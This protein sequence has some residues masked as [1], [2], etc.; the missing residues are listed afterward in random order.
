MKNGG[1]TLNFKSKS[2]VLLLF[3][4]LILCMGVV[5]ANND[6]DSNATLTQQSSSNFDSTDNMLSSQSNDN[7]LSATMGTFKD[8]QNL[9]DTTSGN[10]LALEGDYVYDAG[11]D[12]SLVNGIVINKTFTISSA[13]G[14]KIVINGGNSARL[15]NVTGAVTFNNISFINGNAVDGGAIYSNSTNAITFN[16]CDFIKNTASND[17]GAIYKNRPANPSGNSYVLN[18]CNFYNNTAANYGGAV[19]IAS[20]YGTTTRCRYIDNSANKGGVFYANKSR[21]TASGS[22]FYRNSANTAAVVLISDLG[23][24]NYVTNFANSII[25]QNPSS[26]T[27][28]SRKLFFIED[29]VSAG[30]FTLNNNWWGTT[31]S[32]NIFNIRDTIGAVPEHATLDLWLYLTNDFYFAARNSTNEL[33]FSLSHQAGPSTNTTYNSVNVP[34]F[35]DLIEATSASVGVAGGASKFNATAAYVNYTA[36]ANLAVNSTVTLTLT[37]GGADSQFS[38]HIASDGSYTA[39]Q[40]LI[41]SADSSLYLNRDYGYDSDFD[42]GLMITGVIINKPFIFNGNNHTIDGK[43]L[44]AVISV[45][46]D[47]VILRN[48][49]IDN[50]YRGTSIEGAGIYWKANNAVIDHITTNYCYNLRSQTWQGACIIFRDVGNASNV[51][52][53]NSV[54]NGDD[55]IPNDSF[56]SGIY[57]YPTYGGN[58][59]LINVTTDHLRASTLWVYNADNLY[60]EGCSFHSTTTTSESPNVVASVISNCK[61]VTYVNNYLNFHGTVSFTDN[62]RV[63]NSEYINFTNNTFGSNFRSRGNFAIFR[64]SVLLYF[65]NNTMYRPP[66]YWSN[67]V[68]ALGGLNTGTVIFKDNFISTYNGNGYVV[69]FDSFVDVDVYNNTF[70]YNAKGNDRNV[71][72]ISNDVRVDIY[73][74][75]FSDNHMQLI[76]A[77]NSQELYIYNNTVKRNSTSHGLTADQ[78]FSFLNMGYVLFE[79]NT[80]NPH[81]STISTA[82]EGTMLSAINSTITINNNKFDGYSNSANNAFVQGIFY[83]DNESSTNITNNNFSNCRVYA[84]TGMGLICNLGNDTLICN[85][86]FY[87]TVGNGPING[88]VIYNTG[89]NVTI[90]NNTFNTTNTKGIGG[91]I[92]N[93]GDDVFI[94]YNNFTTN[95]ASNT[96]VIYS[97]GHNVII[98]YCNVTNSYSTS[99]VGAF[100]IEGLANISN[101]Y[102]EKIHAVTDY[103]V[104]YCD[105]AEG[106]IIHNITYLN[107]YATANGMLA[108]G[109]NITIYDQNFTNNYVTNG[110]AGSILIKGNDNNLTNIY[111]YKTRASF[112]GAISNNGDY[113]NITNL[114]IINSTATFSH[115]GAIY[116]IGNNL[117]INILN[118]SNTSSLQDG[119]AIYTTV[120]AGNSFNHISI[121]NTK[122]EHD[123]GAIYCG[124][125]DAKIYDINITNSQSER[126]GGSIY[127][128]G[129]NGNISIMNIIN[130]TAGDSGGAIYWT[131]SEGKLD[132]VTINHTNAS[133]G[134]AIYWT[135]ANGV[136]TQSTIENILSTFDGGAI[137]WIGATPTL[138]YINFTNIVCH[139]NGGAIY[140]TSAN[141]NMDYLIFDDINATGKGG[142]IYWTG[143]EGYLSNSIFT[144]IN[145]SSSGGAI[146]WIGDKSR[147]KSSKFS[148]TY[149]AENGGAI[150]WTGTDSNITNSTFIDISAYGQGGAIYWA[151]ISGNITDSTFINNTA[152]SGGAISWNANNAY[153]YN[154]TIKDCAV[155]SNGGAI[156]LISGSATLDH[157]NLTNNTATKGGA[158]Y[159]IG[160]DATLH[161]LYLYNNT[162]TFDGGAINFDG[163]NGKLYDSYLECNDASGNGGAVNWV[164]TNANVTNVTFS[165]ND[166]R[167]GGAFYL[168]SDDGT[169]FNVTFT[170]NTANTAGAVYMG[171]MYNGKILNATFNNNNATASGGA[172]YWYNNNGLLENVTIDGAN[173]VD[174]GAIYWL[175]DYGEMSGV[176]FDNVFAYQNGGILYIAGYGIEIYDSQFTDSNANNGAGIYWIGHNGKLINVLFE[177]NTVTNNGAGL[178]LVG[179]DFTILNTNFTNNNASNL[180]GGIY[181]VGSGSIDNANF[182]LNSANGGSAIFN[183]GTVSISNT[184]LLNNTANIS[185]IDF[186]FEEF[187]NSINLTATVYGNDNFLNAIYTSS[188]NI[189]VRNVTYWGIDGVMVSADEYITPVEGIDATKLYYDSRVPNIEVGISIRKGNSTSAT[190]YVNNTDI[191]GTIYYEIVK[192]EAVF[193]ITTFHDG[194]SYYA[195]YSSSRL[196]AFGVPEPVLNLILPG[197]VP[198]DHEMNV[199]ISLVAI[200]SDEYGLPVAILVNGTVEVVIDDMYTYDVEVTNGRGSFSEILPL[201][202]G[203]HNISASFAGSLSPQLKNT[204]SGVFNF[205]IVKTPLT[206]SVSTNTSTV[207]VGDP[208]NIT[209]SVSEAYTGVIQYVAGEY[210]DR[211]P[212]YGNYSFEAIYNHEG[213][214][215]VYVIAPGDNNYLAAMGKCS[216]NVVK[217][218]TSLEF[219]NITGYNLNPINVGDPAIITVKLNDNDTT[220]N[221]IININN[222]D[223]TAVIENGYATVTIYNL[224]TNNIATLSY[225]VVATYAGDNKYYASSPITATLPVN[226]IDTE[227]TVTPVNQS[228]FVGADAIFDVNI[229]SLVSDYVVNAYAILLINS[230]EYNVSI[231][232]GTG[233][234]K[235]H[236]LLSGNYSVD[237]IY[238]G[239]YQFNANTITN[240]ANITVDKVDI[241]SIEVIPSSQSIYVGQSANITIKMESNLS[242]YNV[243]GYVTVTIN[244]KKYTVVID[245]NMGSLIVNGLT[246]GNYD[247]NISYG[248]DDIYNAVNDATYATINVDKVDIKKIEVTPVSKDIYVGQSANFTIKL[249]SN[250]TGYD[251]NSFVTVTVDNKQYNV[252]I[253]NNVGS[254]GVDGLNVGSY[255]VNIS[256]EGNA[257][258][259]G[260]PDSKYAQIN[261]NKVGIKNINITPVYQSVDVGQPVNINITMESNIT[262]YDVNDYVTVT[263]NNVQY[264]V[265]ITNNNG[266]LSIPGLAKG[267]YNVTVSYAGSDVFNPV[268]AKNY[269]GAIDVGKVD[270][271]TITVTPDSQSVFVGDEAIFNI[272]INSTNPNYEINDYVTVTIGNNQYNVSISRNNGVLKVS[273]LKAGI[274][275]VNVSYAGSDVYSKKVDAKYATV[276]V[277]KFDVSNIVVNPRSQS[278]LVGQYATIEIRLTPSIAG[279]TI[280]DYVTVTVN[281]KKYNVTINNNAGSLTIVDLNSGNYTVNVSYAGNDRYNS[282]ADATYANITVNKVDIASIII[283]AAE[284]SIYMGQ[285]AVFNIEVITSNPDY[286]FNDFVTV[287]IGSKEYNVSIINGAGSLTVN[288]LNSGLHDVNV[289]YVGSDV[290]NARPTKKLT[291]IVV[292]KVNVENIIV[293]PTSQDVY[294]G[295]YANLTIKMST[296][297][298]GYDINGFVTVTINNKQYNVSIINNTGLLSINNLPYG[299]YRVNV[300]YTGD[301]TYNDVPD[302]TYATIKVNKVDINSISV[303]PSSQDIYVGQVANLTVR[304]T[305]GVVGYNVDGFVTVTVNGKSYNVSISNNVGRLSVLGLDAGRYSVNVAYA[306]SDVYNSLD[307]ATYAFINV[308]KVNI[309][310]I[311]VT[312]TSQSI[313]VGQ[314][315][316]LT[317]RM[318]SG[319]VGYNV[320]GFVTVTVNGKSYNV[321]I[322]NNVGS[323]SVL[324][325]G[326]GRYDVNVAYAGSDVYNSLDDATY[327]SINVNKVDISSIS[328]TPSSQDIYVGQ[329]ANLTVRMTSNVAGYDVNGFVTVTVNNKQY[330]VSISNNVGSF[331]VNGLNNGVWDVNISYAGNDIYNAVP[332]NKYATINVNKVNIGNIYLTPIYQSIDVGQLANINIT[333]EP[334][335]LDYYVNGYVTVTVNNVDYNVSIT[336]NKGSL[337]VPG[338]TNGIY[339]VSVKYNG[340]NIFNPITKN[341]ADVID[342]GKVNIGGITVTPD[343]QS[344][345]V[346]K[347]AIFTIEINPANPDY[348]IDDYVTVTIGD[349]QYNVSIS[350]NIGVLKVSDLKS[351][352]WDVNVSYDGSDVYSKKVDAK[353][354][355]VTVNKIDIKNITVIPKS[356]SILVGQNATIDIILVPNVAGYVINDYITLTVD[357]KQY[358]VSIKDNIGSFT[359][360]GLTEG[361]YSVNISYRGNDIY[362]PLSNRNYANVTVNKVNIASVTINA[363]ESVISVG[364]DAVFDI[365]IIPETPGYVVDNDYVTATVGD[366]QYNVSITNGSGLLTVKGLSSGTYNLD[367]SYAGSDV[368]YPKSNKKVSYITVNKVD[369]ANIVVTPVSQNVYVGQNANLTIKM[370]PTISGYDINDYVTVTIDNKQ[371]NVSIINSTGSISVTGLSSGAYDVKIAYDGSDIYNSLPNVNYASINVDKVGIESIKVTPESQNIY[372]GQAANITVNL[373]SNVT[374]YN[375]NGFV[376]VNVGNKEY[377]VPVINGIGM[378]KLNPLNEGVYDVNV[379]YAGDDTFNSVDNGIYAVINVNKVNIY[380]ITVTPMSQDIYVGQS[381]NVSIRMESDISGYDVN[382]YVTLM[383]DNKAY[384]VSI[385]NNTGSLIIPGLSKGIYDINISYAGDDTFNSVDNAIYAEINVNKVGIESITVIPVSQ[386]IYVG[387]VANL[388]V[389]MKSN[390]TGYNINGYVTVTVNNKEY[391]VS[392]TNNTG[393]VGVNNLSNGEYDVDVY[394]RGDDTFNPVNNDVYAEINVNKVGIESIT[395]TPV[396]QDIYVG[397]VANLTVKMKSNVTGYNINDYVTITVNNKKYNVSISNNTGSFNVSG[398][399]KGTYDVNLSYAGSN[400]YNSKEDATYAKVNVNKVGIESITVTPVVQD[401]YVGQ[402]ANLTVKMKSNVTG[403][404]INGFVT[405][406]VNNV[407][408]N[409]SIINNTG[410][411]SLIDLVND[412]Y[413]VNVFYAGDNVYNSVDDMAYAEI[414]VNKIPTSII[415]DNITMNVGDVA[416]IKA[417][418]NSTEV[419]GNVTFIVD[420][421][422]YVVGIVNGV[423][424]LNVSGLNTSANK[425]ITAI[426][427]GDYKF[428]NS[429]ATAFLNISKVN[430]NAS[431][432]VH[433]ITAGETETV[434]I[435]LPNDVSNGTITVKFNGNIIDYTRD[436]NVIS[437]NRTLQASGNYSVEIRVDDDCKYYDFSNSTSFIVSKVAPENYTIII[438]VNDTFVFENIPVIIKLPNDANKTLSLT[439]DGEL[440]SDS[441]EVVNGVARYTLG[442]L[443]YGN[444]TIGV[445]YNNEKYADK[446]VTASVFV[447]KIA[448]SI[449][450]INPVDPRVAH[451]IIIRVVPEGRSVGNITATI[452]NKNYTVENRSF[453]NASGLL[454][455]NYT[456]VV[457]LA[458]DDNFLESTNTSVFIVKRNPVVMTFNNTVRD[459][460]VDYPVV[461]HV[462]LTANVT[463]SVVFNIGGENYTVNITESDFAEYVWIP[464]GDGMVSVSASYS[465]NDTYYPNSTGIIVF[466]VF[467]NPIKFSDIIVE[468]IMVGDVE[469]IFVSLNESDA[470]GIITININGTEFESTIVNGSVAINASGLS[471]GEY[472]AVAYYGGD[473]KY[474]ATNAIS[475][476][477]TVFKYDS[478][479]SI[480]A[481]DIMI[482]DDAVVIVNIPVDATGNILIT[483]NGE[484]IYIPVVNGSVSWTISNLSSG[485][486]G[487]EAQ[488]SGDYKYLANSSTSSFNVIRYNSTFD[489]ITGGSGWTGED[490]NMSV[491]LSDDATGNVSVSINGT[492]YVLPVVDGRVD[493]TIPE[494]DAGDYEVVVNYTGDYK[495]DNASSV[496]NFTVN[497]NHPIIKAENVVKYYAGSQRLYVNLTNVRGDK[498]SGETLYITVNGV[499]YSRITNDEGVCSIPINLP[500]GEYDVNVVYNTSELYDPIMEVVNVTVLATVEADDLVKIFGNA[501]QY[502]ARFTDSNGNALVN[503]TVSFNINGVF[504]N[505]TTNEDGW[506]KLNIN[507]PAGEYIITAYNPVTGETHANIIKVLPRI[508][509]NYDLVKRYRNASQFTVRI[510]GD[511]GAPVGA[512]ERVEFNIN[513]VFYTRLTDSNGYAKLNINLPAGEY[514]ITTCYM[515][516]Y[517]SNI[518]TVID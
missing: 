466:D 60:V 454:E 312:P 30:S 20:C 424:N 275:D 35:Y 378:L 379:R 301:D 85:N 392:I 82:I 40:A 330:N 237:I 83:F 249:T 383:V 218:Y 331:S 251:V 502:W 484:S 408:Y 480:V 367:V 175:G 270:I 320:D 435:K 423:A 41:N 253:I 426:Y 308:S 395:V 130:S 348:V 396:S 100:Y 515:N 324:G 406:S 370:V 113:N 314:V 323:L 34:Y 355:T 256:Y 154:V 88:A 5:S 8:L 193:N 126:H 285:D 280:N 445:N 63:Y 375:V 457:V 411:L 417:T 341:Y 210:T 365:E 134:G 483:V 162:A 248:G 518:I 475:T 141:A 125:N 124:S 4:I 449:N 346:G 415:V 453:I 266:S 174:G 129:S 111:I 262:G 265:S 233:S 288:N 433:N 224:T 279:Q 495:Y 510:I 132:H 259:N 142:A 179:S 489:I 508:V 284:S 112:G 17:G 45:L 277:N 93:V 441:V 366:K 146:Y 166:A 358:N 149:S 269:V 143:S 506:A 73:N 287:T 71:I 326:A 413:I 194:D 49:T 250:V 238:A 382:G 504:Y 325:L 293:T 44:A 86:T 309:N 128:T 108:L 92:Y 337:T 32:N 219:V 305:S 386:D 452:N 258:Y 442:N 181:W 67:S 153:M 145:A 22:L 459:V 222:N 98:D 99:S 402:V 13:T 439:V 206:I 283:T 286:M 144:N 481:D 303:T 498:L 501:S 137:Y 204:S 79:N 199:T 52:I 236:N 64:A 421:K 328:V 347:E 385:S 446:N 119:G 448:S 455:G 191:S 307:D 23:T 318:T 405:L 50:G 344:V 37:I 412:T 462:D 332:N 334:D 101:I 310:S 422:I 292:N 381:A 458:E 503:T 361:N 263:V 205:T 245:N 291:A 255:D 241:K 299:E 208:I 297:I 474:L 432:I 389:E 14:N 492:D 321:S 384:N 91:S 220:G 514:I 409:V 387:Q 242:N 201:F 360:G 18:D 97:V 196:I 42:E 339:D 12:G 377:T 24:N 58:V 427:S 157:L 456:V 357:N 479:M 399:N 407:K 487:V 212:I 123:G 317:V 465:G 184:T 494:L 335:V 26:D 213:T 95:V 202:A 9:I 39:L 496:F 468:D 62:F 89:N 271:D 163:T 11:V 56:Q 431:I 345:F 240:I 55:D 403:Y 96:G 173:S 471:A 450:I 228:I 61:N 313:Y 136:L 472:N 180:G 469:H 336:N 294:V 451:D 410:V 187:T 497:S 115:G 159:L 29:Y 342:V 491:I 75:T 235:V 77:S 437:F 500:S 158:I 54:F 267:T 189:Q 38:F 225:N 229:N 182:S 211:V 380:S 368:Y 69:G 359:I 247:V 404:D 416:N 516:S 444:H 507:L 109:S 319:V 127:W 425:T 117:T 7:N 232:N 70:D 300:L 161:E 72:Q 147:I 138:T 76:G 16:F 200:T 505:R 133:N 509:E 352:V 311:T 353:Y 135:G 185:S 209:V 105:N 419:S 373:K 400:I 139:S 203:Q 3:I 156:N 66:A 470:T 214:V 440:I 230:V 350:K 215:D 371:Y 118:I 306:G 10:T 122:S 155:E 438:D 486:Y 246:S 172:I 397:Q 148:N 443:S 31:S 252:S 351:G 78:L 273:D 2:V 296:G 460:M 84:K 80:I 354:A 488:Y 436:N 239:D 290:Y 322:S 376:T 394:Y 226:K 1:L 195:N 170:N 21:I 168:G 356:Q 190:I 28:T 372:V 490:I 183:G 244:N 103:G 48:V 177:N 165:N 391:I 364:Q 276:T 227:I 295:Q 485:V 499:T 160:S 110:E 186:V 429:T 477:F 150:Y 257:I 420:N 333:L 171:G 120:G 51:L 169:L 178:Y 59:T 461:L 414:R 315:A 15:F 272:R 192:S 374:G 478:P 282:M 33:L 47:D 467:R 463:G 369:I 65:E 340:S 152:D 343:S 482:L 349:N 68:F 447:S 418:I 131:G 19:Y 217:K 81:H 473:F 278:I 151:G 512:G 390:V 393:F 90:E 164:G 140:G 36:P 57:L 268:V 289:S 198:Y 106:T 107:N 430:G 188:N 6:V 298:S 363:I 87:N 329:V 302:S 338:L 74:N 231:T 401:I 221:V 167:I 316:N 53:T 223:Y 327:A 260:L 398:L 388:T 513:G 27:N 46:S 281:N 434:I 243:S 121:D 476:T 304:M 493:F 511:D 25:L 116:S 104:I 234:I 362:N 197:D 261:V 464:S 428:I 102:F 274:W 207:N 216:F 114:T 517:A 94:R 254:I 264:N 176:T 43:H